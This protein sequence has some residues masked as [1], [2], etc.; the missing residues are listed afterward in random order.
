ML[1][2]GWNHPER[3][4]GWG[5]SLKEMK[6]SRAQGKWRKKSQWQRQLARKD[7]GPEGR[8]TGAPQS[9]R[10]GGRIR[11]R[12]DEPRPGLRFQLWRIHW[13]PWWGQFQP[14]GGG[15]AVQLHWNRERLQPRKWTQQIQVA[16]SRKLVGKGKERQV[17]WGAGRIRKKDFLPLTLVGGDEESRLGRYA[18]WGKET[19]GEREIESYRSQLMVQDPLGVV[20]IVEKKF[21]LCGSSLRVGTM[22]YLS[23]IPSNTWHVIGIQK[24]FIKI[25]K[26]FCF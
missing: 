16:L 14:K 1:G 18:C 15:S 23:N 6:S 3:R 24:M 22:S 4:R 9:D 13:C 21:L 10:A 8:G 11:C 20:N 5:G 26:D 19:D 7:R 2:V 25:S 12:G 17:G